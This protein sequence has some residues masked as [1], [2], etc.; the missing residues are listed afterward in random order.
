MEMLAFASHLNHE[1]SIG[2]SELR[3]MIHVLIERT[4]LSY[5]SKRLQCTPLCTGFPRAAVECSTGTETKSGSQAM[6]WGGAAGNPERLKRGPKW[7]H[8]V[9]G[10]SN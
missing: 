8:T 9:V 10:I 6:W 2:T 3:S 4:A 1:L 7:G 5:I